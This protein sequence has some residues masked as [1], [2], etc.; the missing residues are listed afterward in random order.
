MGWTVLREGGP[1]SFGQSASKSYRTE[2]G[3]LG[4]APS[5]DSVTMDK[6]QILLEVVSS[7]AERE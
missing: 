1:V 3:N 6:S 7:S 2:S 5:T 4:P